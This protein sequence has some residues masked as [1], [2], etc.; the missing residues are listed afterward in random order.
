MMKPQAAVLLPNVLV[1][2]QRPVAVAQ[3]PPAEVPLFQAHGVLVTSDCVVARGRTQPLVDVLRVESIRR[4]PSLRP[5]LATLA[6]SMSVGFPLLSALSV[7]ASAQSG[8]YE[9]GLVLLSLVFFGSIARLLLAEDSY[10]VV[11]HTRD[12]AWRVLSSQEARTSTRLTALLQEA[13]SSAVRR[14]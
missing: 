9:A 3:P 13:V 4:S 5:V 1:F 6:L 7:A 11:V 12:G 10:Q 8:L 2:P 14:R